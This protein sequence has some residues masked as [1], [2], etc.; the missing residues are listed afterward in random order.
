M[1]T[2]NR[3]IEVL[4]SEY[5]RF[6]GKLNILKEELRIKSSQTSIG[7]EKQKS[8]KITKENKSDIETQLSTFKE[9][10]RKSEIIQEILILQKE[11]QV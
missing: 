8:F 10:E 6:Q 1:G 4:E 5:E 11:I 2:L 3:R 7:N 9:Q